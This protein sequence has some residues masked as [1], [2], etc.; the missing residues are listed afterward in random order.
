MVYDSYER[1]LQK[2][3]LMEYSSEQD[4]INSVVNGVAA[5]ESYKDASAGTC[6]IYDAESGKL[7]TTMVS[8]YKVK[9]N[10]K[11]DVSDVLVQGKGTNDKFSYQYDD[12]GI[13]TSKTVNGV[14]ITYTTIDG[15][16]TSQDGSM[17]KIYFRYDKD[18]QLVGF[19]RNGA[20]LALYI[21]MQ[22]T[23]GNTYNKI[24]KCLYSVIL[25]ITYKNTIIPN[26]LFRFLPLLYL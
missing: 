11:G 17:N 25:G 23:S 10:S 1:V 6:Y 15:R 12:N 24:H 8:S 21:L 18:N 2:V 20:W 19:N 9:Y 14:T 3:S 22:S 7:A 4:S 13:R 16:I 5:D 26:D